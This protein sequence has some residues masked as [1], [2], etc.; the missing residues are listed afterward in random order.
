[1]LC[2]CHSPPLCTWP[3][4]FRSRILVHPLC[5]M[6]DSLF[7]R[8]HWLVEYSIRWSLPFGQKCR[9][10]RNCILVHMGLWKEKGFW[11]INWL[12][13]WFVFDPAI[14]LFFISPWQLTYSFISWVSAVL[15][16]YSKV[17]C[18]QKPNGSIKK[19]KKTGRHFTNPTLFATFRSKNRKLASGPTYP[20][21]E[22]P[23]KTIC[24]FFLNFSF[25]FT[26]MVFASFT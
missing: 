6:T 22:V 5:H 15:S 7:Q 23:A 14:I 9:R 11:L 21:K 13:D 3:C 12:I 26:R 25:L 24:C 18:H 2:C 19:K 4:D 8:Y 10:G 16:W 1:M 20:V 17:H